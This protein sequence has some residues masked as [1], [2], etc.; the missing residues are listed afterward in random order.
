MTAPLKVALL[1][2]N[3]PGYQSLALGY[4]RAYAQA[5]ERLKGRVGFQTLDL[6]TDDDPWWISYRIIGL[7]P[8]VL[9]VSVFCWS[10]GAIYDIC[11]IVRQA[12]PDVRIVLGGPEVGPIAESVLRAHPEIDAIIRGE[13]EA[14]FADVLDLARR[15]KPFSRAEGVTARD[16]SGAPLAAPDRPL[17]PQ[18]DSIPSPYLTGVLEPREGSA[19]IE[20]FRGCPHECAYCF[21]GKGYARVRSFGRERVEAEIAYLAGERGVRQFSFIDSVFNLTGER[22]EWLAGVLAPYAARGL[23]LHTVEV[24][25]ERI[26]DAAAEL[27]R[28]AGVISVET[29]P[30]SIGDAALATCRRRFDPER[31][32]AGVAAL[33]R[34]GIS[35]ETD[36]IAGLPGDTAEDFLAGVA[37]CLELD[38]GK[39]QTSTLHVLP[40]TALYSDADELGLRF[41]PEP[42]H[43]IVATRD[44][45]FADLRRLEAR[46]IY[47]ARL[48]A[49]RI[50]G[51]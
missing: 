11:R 46:S 24:D 41:D 25:I 48:Y 40:G 21:E 13:G 49:A 12:L 20:T 51:E 26:D 50:E 39:I 14:A 9:A 8:D 30:Q 43:E 35:V 18:L 4:L 16:A 1:A 17:I 28:S 10:A 7:E 19:Y 38:P 44:I 45:G 3:S 27:L 6:T 29:G 23:T 33:K 36:L 22:L 31:F 32:T 15:A 37:F 34:Q 2:L 47:I 5:D 42:P